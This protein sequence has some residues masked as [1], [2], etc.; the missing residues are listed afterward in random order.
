MTLLTSYRPA[1]ILFIA[2][3][4]GG[5]ASQKVDW[6][7]DPG[8]PVEGLKSYR[9][10]E[11]KEDLQKMGYQFDALMDQRVQDAVDRTLKLRGY[12]RLAP[13]SSAEADFLVNYLTSTKTRREEHQVTT[14]F[15]YGFSPWG[16]GLSTDT[17]VQEYEEGTLII[18]VIDPATKK[19]IWRG[20]SKARI[21]DNLSP[22]ERTARINEAVSNIL[23]G[24]PRPV[25]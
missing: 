5:C 14:S 7:F 9:W 12:Q 4:L 15:G 10:M 1:V 23:E 22:Q 11:K 25:K 21:K 24:F 2:I 20:R 19:V 8:R 17:R 13:S 16:L 6:D 3:A 18:D